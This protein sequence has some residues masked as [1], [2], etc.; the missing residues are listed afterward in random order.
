MSTTRP[1]A[2]PPPLAVL[3]GGLAAGVID[4]SYACTF[5]AIKAGTPPTR[6]LQSVAAGLLGRR[7]GCRPR[8]LAWPCTSS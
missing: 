8:H 2:V 1:R 3:A 6:I 7:A 5:W 4:I